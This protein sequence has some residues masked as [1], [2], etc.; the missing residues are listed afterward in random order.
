MTSY[1]SSRSINRAIATAALGLGLT[2]FAAP[3]ANA[4]VI[5]SSDLTFSTSTK[6]EIT[7]VDP[8][9][10]VSEFYEA[11]GGTEIATGNN[12]FFG[13]LDGTSG[14]RV[15]NRAKVATVDAAVANDVY[16]TFT[17]DVADGMQLDL[18]SLK[19]GMQM[20]S[21]TA[22]SGTFWVHL[23]SSA[24]DFASDI[25]LPVSLAGNGTAAADGTG[26]FDLA[27][28]PSLTG[29]TTF[30]LYMVL[31]GLPTNPATKYIRIMPDVILEGDVSP[32]PEPG[33]LALAGLGGLLMLHRRRASARA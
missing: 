4:A 26:A 19:I 10:A 20:N 7:A 14:S 5:V 28:L 8:N 13:R 2:A 11:F 27:G 6:A 17:I 31:N 9:V 29:E 22:T 32:V 18:T 15:A 12:H 25:A 3:A 23:R 16:G 30:N 24:D 1:F 33:T 21:D